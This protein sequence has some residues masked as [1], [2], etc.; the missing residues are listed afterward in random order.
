MAAYL[1]PQGKQQ[2]FSTAGAPLVG[3]KVW[4]YQAGST[5]P[6]ATYSDAAGTIPNA[7]PV[8]LDSRG[9]ASIFFSAAAYKV[10]LQD[11]T[12]ASIW[13]QDNLVVYAGADT[14]GYTP[15]G[16]GAVATTV[17]SKLRESVS[18]KDFGADA[19]GV[20]DSTSAFLAAAT[21]SLSVFIPAGTYKLTSG[22]LSF[23]TGVAFI[24]A[25]QGAV[26][27][28]CTSGTSN[29]FSWTGS[30]TGGGMS[31][32]TINGSGMTGGNLISNIGQSRWTVKDCQLLNGYNG[33]YVQDQNMSTL[34]NLFLNN[35]IG[36]YGIKGYGSG[37]GAFNVLDINNIAIGFATNG[38][39]SPVGVILDGDAA[40]I[41]MRH[42]QV[43]KGY[44]G[45]SIVNT[46]NFTLGPSF[47][48]AYDFQSDYTYD[49]CI[50]IDG[51]TGATQGH[52]FTDFYAHGSLNSN[53]ITITSSA[54]SL[55]FKGG[56]ID[57][58]WLRGISIA[59]RYIKVT[60]CQIAANSIVGSAV[61]PGVEIG[62]TSIG[63]HLFGN[64]IG[65]W[66]G[67]AVETQSY[68]VL[69]TAGA[70][71]YNVTGNNLNTNVTGPYLDNAADSTSVIFG[72]SIPA[73]SKHIVNAPIQGMPSQ[74]LALYGG[75]IN[76]VVMGNATNGLAFEA[77][78]QTSAINHLIVYG[79]A[80]GTAP[81]IQATGSTDLDIKLL[82]NGTG[83]AQM[84]S[85]GMFAA[86]GA[87]ATSL[88]S[89]G[90]TGASTTVVK[91]LSIKDNGG[92]LRYIP[93]W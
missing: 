19:T 1:M 37:T 29:L 23:S 88:G 82:A 18:V 86:N 17:Q 45:L 2:Y 71:A 52:Q 10:A 79:T 9:E 60:G 80:S 33:I 27:L 13:T 41:D 55:N 78:A 8:I 40:T 91:W 5:T 67:V 34:S 75:G 72:N 26:T 62:A 31:G 49:A 56:Q 46:P 48:S 65:Q 35:Q 90:P 22:S 73:S 25:G 32:V 93:C 57:S 83:T 51:G 58:N 54:R 38:A 70:T 61:Q 28:N 69:V 81:A 87:V 12:G 11:S 77:Q 16:T 21:A 4:T 53:G 76:R 59:G 20:A 3:G 44:R 74:N 15:A 84:G 68:G 6:L 92:T 50:Y 66:T 36:A 85:A 43:V 24:G 47:L 7:N 14:V 89:V 64:L 63:T 42:V 30:A 39:T